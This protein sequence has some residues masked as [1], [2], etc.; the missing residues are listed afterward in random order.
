[1][2]SLSLSLSLSVSLLESPSSSLRFLLQFSCYGMRAPYE[3]YCITLQDLATENR[4]FDQVPNQVLIVNPHQALAAFQ[5]QIQAQI[6][7]QVA[8]QARIPTMSQAQIAMANPMT[9]YCLLSCLGASNAL[10][11]DVKE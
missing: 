2:L 4:D 10:G 5:P 7:I 3:L 1:M 8:N 11:S 6:P 9:S